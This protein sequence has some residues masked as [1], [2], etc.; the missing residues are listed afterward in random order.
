MEEQNVYEKFGISTRQ[1]KE[2]VKSIINQK[3]K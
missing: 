1:I 2:A 3:S